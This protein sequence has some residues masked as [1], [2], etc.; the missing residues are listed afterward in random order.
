MPVRNDLQDQV[1]GHA[2]VDLLS[3]CEADDLSYERKGHPTPGEVF[4]AGELD[5]RL[6]GLDW[7]VLQ[8][9]LEFPYKCKGDEKF[10]PAYIQRRSGHDPQ[11]V[12]MA[13][14][15]LL[16]LGY[17]VRDRSSSRYR[18]GLPRDMPRASKGGAA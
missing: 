14:R 16:Q 13:Q 11:L 8:E 3:A 12:I 4:E 10:G 6:S 17:V 18:L 2:G 1:N 9:V 5:D 15:K 7:I